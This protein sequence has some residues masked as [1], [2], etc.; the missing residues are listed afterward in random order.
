[1][2]AKVLIVDDIATNR[3]VL[4]VKLSAAG[5]CVLQAASAEEALQ[6]AG[7]EQPQ[8]VLCPTRL[9]D[10]TTLE[11]I[12]A[13]EDDPRLAKISRIV[14][15]N[16]LDTDARLALLAAGATDILIKP[17]DVSALLARFRAILRNNESLEDTLLQER[18][19]RVLG[20]GETS[21]QFEP[22]GGEKKVHVAV[23]SSTVNAA[24][25]WS[26]QLS[27]HPGADVRAFAF[28]EVMVAL[29]DT[30]LPDVIVI[31]VAERHAQK[32]LNLL[33]DLR[34]SSQTRHAKIIAVV[35]TAQ[36][37]F[38]GEALDRGSDDVLA[39]GFC[40][41][42]LSLRIRRQARAKRRDDK[43][44]ANMHE[45]LRAATI[46]ALTGLYN[47]RFALP[48]L[49]RVA[50]HCR[51][52]AKSCAVMAIDVDHFKTVNDRFGHE[53]G[54]AALVALAKL[55]G[56]SLR[57]GDIASRI[58]G[59]EFMIILPDTTVEAAHLAAR[60]LCETVATHSFQLPGAERPVQLTV[61]IGVAVC[62][63]N[64]TSQSLEGATAESLLREADVALYGSKSHGRNQVTLSDQS[65]A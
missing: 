57:G 63:P 15:C 58:G 13:F 54:D 24:H 11:F 3:I 28:D 8:L 26:H 10:S 40:L 44:R 60:R 55:F 36:P 49:T 47:R 12:K 1:M 51:R 32:A 61:S 46:D 21:V 53:A 19:E 52:E 29:D 31:D 48:H 56:E 41:R 5:Y 7:R 64:Q 6:V 65:A 16:S 39:Y 23:M 4:H 30:A 20:F 22:T 33:S 18:M 17:P 34:A 14:L 37:A 50:S 42:E 59:E 45:G 35:P 25:N 38:L 43:R 9:P 62:E 27:G 2:Q